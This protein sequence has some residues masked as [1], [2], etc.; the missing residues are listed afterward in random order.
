MQTKRKALLLSIGYGQ[1]HHTAAQAL[2]EELSQRGWETQR[3]DL[4]AETS[5]KLFRATQSFYRACV[6]SMPRLWG[7]LYRLIERINWARMTYA[8]GIRACTEGLRRLIQD[9]QPQLIICTYPLYGYMLDALAKESGQSVPYAMVVTDAL[10]LCRPWLLTQAELICL[11]DELSLAQVRDIYELPG[12][13]VIATGFP[14]RA[15][16]RADDRRPLP[17]ED[18]AGLHIVYAAHA[19][20]QQV[21]QDMQMLLREWPQARISLLAEERKTALC[22]EPTLQ[23]VEVYGEGQSTAE[24]MQTAHFYIG[25]AGAASVFEA[26][27]TET[28]VLVNYVLPGQEQGNLKLLEH[29]G[30]GLYVQDTAS[31]ADTLHTLLADSARGWQDMCRAIRRA[32]RCRGAARTID[33]LERRM[34]S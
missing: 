7:C 14:V 10:S 3:H 27:T 18:G 29:D 33:A 11:P 22:D 28:P 30:A 9:E 26:Y 2:A 15:A 21:K 8:P 23:G 16:F 13:R 12:G 24:L 34:F 4:C 1:G 6:R 5:P 32:D 31:L 20:L 19:P 17:A 25:K